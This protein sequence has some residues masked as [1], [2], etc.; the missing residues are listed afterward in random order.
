MKHSFP[1][2]PCAARLLTLILGVLLILPTFSLAQEREQ[3]L[4]SPKRLVHHFDFED[5]NEQGIKIGSSYPLPKHWYAVGRDPLNPD[6]NFLNLPVHADLIARERY[7]SYTHVGFDDSQTYSGDYALHL[8]LDGGNAAAF[9]QV[10]ALPVLTRSDYLI[11][12]RFR[13][14]KLRGAR[15]AIRSYFVNRQGERIADS[16]RSTGPIR[17]ENGWSAVS[18]KLIG[19]YPEAAWIGLEV[20]LLQPTDSPDNPLGTQQIVLQDLDAKLWVD[21]I[22]VWLLPH[23]EIGTQDPTNLI[24]SPQQPTINATVRDLTGQ[25]LRVEINLYD[26]NRT[27]VEQRTWLVGDG[28]ADTWDWTPQLPGFGWYLVELAVFET[29]GDY[30]GNQPL[31]RSIGALAYMPNH[32]LRIAP[33]LE[34]FTLIAERMP[35]IEERLIPSLL[36]RTGLRSVVLSVWNRETTLETLNAEQHHL[37]NLLRTIMG[38]NRSVALSFSP[39]PTAL[40]Q[41]PGIETTSP[42]TLLQTD[43]ELWQPFVAPVMLRHGQRIKQWHLGVLD[44]NEPFFIE[45]LSD[46][47]R[48]I[49]DRLR[50]LSPSPRLHLPWRIDQARRDDMPS[51]IA[52]TIEVPASIQPESVEGYLESWMSPPLMHS[53]RLVESNAQNYPHAQRLASL[54][55]RMVMGWVAGAEGLSIDRP[56][57]TGFERRLAILPDPLLP[58]FANIAQLLAERRYITRLDLGEQRRAIV[59][60]GSPGSLMVLWDGAS[61]PSD[62]DM[63]LGINPKASDI[64]GNA[65]SVPTIDRKHSLTLN[66]IP[67]FVEGIDVQLARL[68]AS[69][70]IDD[71][72]IPSTQVVHRRTISLINPFSVTMQ[73]RLTF[74]GPE[75]WRIEPVQHDFTLDPGGTLELPIG[76]SFPIQEIAGSKVLVAHAVFTSNRT[77]DVD[78]TLPLELGLRDLHVNSSLSLVRNDEGGLDAV[79]IM[80]V[81]NQAEESRSFYGFATMRDRRGLERIIARL[82]PGQTVIER[83]RFSDVGDV[84][85]TTPIRL[86]VREARGPA[87][88]NKRLSFNDAF[89]STGR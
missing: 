62:L 37:E 16:E 15:A 38:D 33:D 45:R 30:A 19:N 73:G 66:E 14:E 34:R 51:N 44:A 65:S 85:E 54:A 9:L 10:G 63:Y 76:L 71:P 84:I 31:A 26:H 4:V 79:A 78:L 49:T 22:G 59:F 52:Y 55:R 5:T 18:I 46:T 47:T 43:E 48:R 60:D 69:F 89:E 88:L 7:P 53:L 21:D 77:Y 39:V 67:I 40:A 23:V 42:M 24:V 86:G 81:T 36:E 27:R 1:G 3:V 13:T 11:T 80:V 41:T 6:P 2:C 72:F 87:M 56:W 8:A 50:R 12:A 82:N 25:L 20:E 58:A 29:E 35:P 17:S 83:F 61:E 28:S 75:N 74:T 68:R 32:R 70:T 57:T 64:W